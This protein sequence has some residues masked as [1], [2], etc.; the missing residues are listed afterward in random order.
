MVPASVTAT[1]VTT[2]STNVTL[3]DRVIC[4]AAATGTTIRALTSSSP[5]TRMAT[6]TVTA[7]VTAISRFSTRT[8]SP[9]TRA[10]S[11]SWLTANSCRRSPTVTSSTNAASRAIAVMS[12]EETVD[13]EP[14]RYEVRLALEPVS[15]RLISRTP[16]AMPP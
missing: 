15:E 7:A 3:N 9:V 5:T 8:G 1:P 16:P 2:E 6:V 12:S 14:K 11:S 13:S 4:C 10:N